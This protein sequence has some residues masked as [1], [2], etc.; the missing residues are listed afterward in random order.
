M[1]VDGAGPWIAYNNG[2][3]GGLSLAWSGSDWSATGGH[4]EYSQTAY[5]P[6]WIRQA[7]MNDASRVVQFFGTVQADPD[8]PALFTRRLG[9]TGWVDMGQ[10]V[11][12]EDGAP[13][14]GGLALGPDGLLYRAYVQGQNPATVVIEHWSGTWQATIDPI[15][16]S[17]AVQDLG[18]ASAGG[19]LVSWYLDAAGELTL[20]EIEFPE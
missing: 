13:Y 7:T 18:L 9:S 11:T 20:L 3:Y 14:H 17:E 16:V 8:E 10:P 1:S 4:L 15:S 12:I 19:R 6:T 5:S 2:D